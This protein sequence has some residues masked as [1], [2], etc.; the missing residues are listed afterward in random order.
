MTEHIPAVLLPIAMSIAF[1]AKSFAQDIAV[2]ADVR[3]QIT[4]LQSGSP[5]QE[6]AAA[7]PAV[8]LRYLL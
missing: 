4:K 5:K 6:I 3:K 7:R 2:A 1:P 8:I